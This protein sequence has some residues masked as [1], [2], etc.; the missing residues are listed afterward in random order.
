VGVGLQLGRE[1]LFLIVAPAA[2]GAGGSVVGSAGVVAATGATG[3]AACGASDEGTGGGTF[4]ATNG[5]A[6]GSAGDAATA[7]TT[8][9]GARMGGDA[10]DHF[11]GQKNCKAETNE[12]FHKAIERG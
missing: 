3:H 9:D 5:S 2:W 7:A 10:T 8:D 4:P 6:D 12:V 11:K 1:V